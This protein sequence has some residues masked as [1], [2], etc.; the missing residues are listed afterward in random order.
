MI[1]RL[2]RMPVSLANASLPEELPP[3]DAADSQPEHHPKSRFSE[4][5]RELIQPENNRLSK[6]VKSVVPW[7]GRDGA[8]HEFVSL[9]AQ[10]RDSR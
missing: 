9:P 4:G 8:L 5:T 10:T 7:S 3:T 6:L 1:T 2:G